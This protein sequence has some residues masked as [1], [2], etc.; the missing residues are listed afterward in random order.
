MIPEFYYNNFVVYRERLVYKGMY[1][2][3]VGGWRRRER[4]RERER[5]RGRERERVGEDND[6]NANVNATHFAY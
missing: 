1:F 3:V 4:R 2:I 6:E 5:E